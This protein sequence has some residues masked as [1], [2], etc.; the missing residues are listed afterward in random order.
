MV[1]PLE[2]LATELVIPMGPMAAEWL[3]RPVVHIKG[4]DH[5]GMMYRLS[6]EV[7]TGPILARGLKGPSRLGH[8]LDIGSMALQSMQGPLVRAAIVV[9]RP[10]RVAPPQGLWESPARTM[11]DLVSV[12]TSGL[13]VIGVGL[14]SRAPMGGLGVPTTSHYVLAFVR[15]L[16][17]RRRRLL[18]LL[19]LGDIAERLRVSLR[20]GLPPLTTRPRT[21]TTSIAGRCHGCGTL[22]GYTFRMQERGMEAILWTP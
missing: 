22:H 14:V 13:I 11:G 9:V 3:A 6:A 2:L 4:C 5:I 20:S 21:A 7:P 17:D 1:L 18:P 16:L 10:Q 19:P 15:S 8:G 12:V